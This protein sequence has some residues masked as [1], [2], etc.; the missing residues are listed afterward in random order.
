MDTGVEVW[1]RQDGKDAEKPEELWIQAHI[2]KKVSVSASRG[3]FSGG[4]RAN[5]LVC[6][7]FLGP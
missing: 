4:A 7:R 3:Y 1:I 2:T 6:L 5:D